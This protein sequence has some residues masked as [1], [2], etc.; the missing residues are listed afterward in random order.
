MS[1][2]ELISSQLDGYLGCF[3]LLATMHKATKNIEVQVCL[4][5]DVFFSLG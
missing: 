1:L 2:T 4:W 5:K 3:R